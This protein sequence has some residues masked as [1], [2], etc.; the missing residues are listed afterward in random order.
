MKCYVDDGSRV[1]DSSESV[2]C[3]SECKTAVLYVL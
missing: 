2:S 1:Q 3:V